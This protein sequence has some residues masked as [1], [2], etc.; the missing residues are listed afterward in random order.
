MH[1]TLWAGG[2]FYQSKETSEEPQSPI[3]WSATGLKVNEDISAD[4]KRIISGNPFWDDPDLAHTGASDMGPG[5]TVGWEFPV[6]TIHDAFSCLASHCDGVIKALQH[7][8]EM[9]YQGFD[10]LQ[11]FLDSVRTGTYPLRHRD[12]RWI[13]N[14]DQFN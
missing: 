3:S 6:V 11:R 7:N 2:R 12:Y 9:M 4:S 5:D 13:P 14:P 10:P 1:G 8:F